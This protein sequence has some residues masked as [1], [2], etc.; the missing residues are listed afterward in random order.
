LLSNN[1]LLTQPPQFWADDSAL[2]FIETHYP[3]YLATYTSYPYPIQQK[4]A[5][6][7]F[8]LYHYGGI[9]LDLDVTPYRHLDPLLT[10]PAFARLTTPTGISSDALGSSPRHPFFL[11]VINSL[12]KSNRNWVSPYI[13]VMA[14]TGPLFLSLRWKEWLDMSKG[15]AT[16]SVVALR[17]DEREY[18]YRGFFIDIEG[19]SWQGPD[20]RYIAWLERHWA[21]D[22]I[23]GNLGV[24]CVTW[25]LWET[26]WHVWKRAEI[27]GR[28][29]VRMRKRDIEHGWSN[30]EKI[31]C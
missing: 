25:V 17:M 30:G 10:L 12:S 20:E 29:G 1:V 15:G 24:I 7:Y 19:R 26:F 9:Y 21:L 3:D 2:A 18:G 5:I 28:S 31:K 8:I 22:I 27:A 16:N 14:S 11:Y 23:L 13:T 6:R 4:D